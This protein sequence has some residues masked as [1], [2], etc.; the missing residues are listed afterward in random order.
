MSEHTRSVVDSWQRMTPDEAEG[1]RAFWLR[2]QANVEG[3]EAV[4]RARQVVTRVLAADGELLAVSTA[5]PRT[6]P[7]L[8]Q[9]MF[10]YRCFV[11]AASRDGTLGRTLLRHDFDVLERWSRERDFPCI[12]VLLELENSGFARTL[13]QAYWPSTGFAFIGC[14]AR[15][16][17][18]R[19]R[20]F[21][22]A[23]LKFPR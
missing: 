2:E 18:L 9:P 7:R 11:G 8:R 5:E 15:G 17:D 20:Y 4:R 14:S 21:R 16:L 13:Q 22:G 19:V 6:I 12:G 3:E 1:V 23:R 10:Y